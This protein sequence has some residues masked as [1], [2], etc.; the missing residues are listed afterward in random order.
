MAV[1]PEV[2]SSGHDKFLQIQTMCLSQLIGSVRL[3]PAGLQ[4]RMAISI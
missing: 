1:R 4:R 3:G 2:V